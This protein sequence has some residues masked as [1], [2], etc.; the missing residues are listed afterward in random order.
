MHPDDYHDE[1]RERCPLCNRQ[2]KK[3]RQDSERDIWH[4]E[5]GVC[6]QFGITLEV[7]MAFSSGELP[8]DI[9]LPLSAIVR[10]HF[11]LSHEPEILTTTNCR[12]L[13][14][15]APDKADAS[16]KL[17]FLLEYIAQ[18]SLSAG[19]K[20][21]LKAE[22]D[23]PVCF[24]ANAEEFRFCLRHGCDRRY[25]EVQS[26]MWDF[27]CWLTPEG[28][29]EVKR[30]SPPDDANSV[31]TGCDGPCTSSCPDLPQWVSDI[32]RQPESDRL[33]F[34]LAVSD[35]REIAKQLSALANTEG[36]LLVLG[37]REGGDVVG[38]EDVERAEAT[39]RMAVQ[40]VSPTI[41]VG[42][43]C[44]SI[45][46]RSFVIA[47]V[48]KGEE[49]PHTVSGQAYQRVGDRVVRL[50]ETGRTLEFD[51]FLAH[52]AEDKPSVCAI[53]EALKARGVRVWLDWSR[54]HLVSNSRMPY[55]E[56]FGM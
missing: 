56:H 44:F 39:I 48:T 25:L 31:T 33:E 32:L 14:L 21:T 55:N 38:L 49:L 52:N 24:A 2:P 1:L 5:C 53:S 7:L 17:Q 46:N 23:Y 3:L 29:E 6:S 20:V 51:V 28:W 9:K 37:V 8:F 18:K 11:E 30:R 42:T 35:Q 13:A 22:T 26:T 19:Q 54:Y 16:R 41:E 36:G 10:R 4:V 15:Q 43:E 27:T 40:K 45:D 50:S 47:T 12:D 34:K